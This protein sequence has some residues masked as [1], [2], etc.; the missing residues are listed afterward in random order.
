MLAAAAV[1][2][3]TFGV[4]L[5]ILVAMVDGNL[6]CSDEN[7]DVRTRQ[8]DRINAYVE[9]IMSGRN[10]VSMIMGDFNIDGR[11]LFG[12]EY[13][14]MLKSLRIGPATNT[15]SPPSDLISPFPL[16]FTDDVDHGDLARERVGAAGWG[17][18]IVMAK[19]ISSPS[20][21][22]TA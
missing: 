17:K 15:D 5:P 19:Q 22:S 10:R 8:L 21:G 18:A 4:W 11:N 13:G 20:A 2:D 9:Q 1:G 3:P 14:R 12:F 6:N 7:H 16:D